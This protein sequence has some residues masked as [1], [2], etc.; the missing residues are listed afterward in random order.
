[1]IKRQ[2]KFPNVSGLDQELDSIVKYANTDISAN[3]S[4]IKKEGQSSAAL[5][6]LFV[7]TT[8]GGSPTRQLKFKTLTLSDGTKLNV[9]V[10]D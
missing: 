8:S 6:G 5:V 2:N 9:L 7:A 4:L 3:T 1:M 10:T